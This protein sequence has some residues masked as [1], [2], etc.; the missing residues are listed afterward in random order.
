MKDYQKRFS[1]FLADSGA[2]FFD[3][4]LILKDRRP[5]PYFVNFGKIN[6]GK[7]INELGSRYADMLVEKKMV[8]PVDIIFGP[9]YKGSAIA[10]ATAFALWINHGI[11][12]MF[13]YD[14]KEEKTHGEA[15]KLGNLLVNNT[16]FNNA[17]LYMTDDV[18]TSAA[19][20][21]EGVEKL[22]EA[23]AARNFCIHIVGTGIAV[24]R[25]QVGPV[26]DTKGRILLGERGEDS[27]E[28]FTKDTGIPIHS[29]VGIRDAIHH[30]HGNKYPL[31]INK[32]KQ[33]MDAETFDNFQKYMETYGVKR[34]DTASEKVVNIPLKN[35]KVER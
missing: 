26:Y 20:K 16:L 2:L 1:E 33:P 17:R 12:K 27:I 15:S 24:D 19:T 29:I 28:K 7:L 18:V 14:R 5:T 30:L 3:E 23:A 10:L 21:Y 9:S 35:Y 25:E 31:S 32:K 6:T 11:D 4:G 34:P 8:E 13:E 22:N